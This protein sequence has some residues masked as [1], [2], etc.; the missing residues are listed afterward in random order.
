MSHGGGGDRWL[1]SYADFITLLMILFLVLYSMGQTDIEKYKKLAEGLKA[2]FGGGPVRIVDPK[3][4]QFGGVSDDSEPAPILI[5]DMPSIQISPEDVAAEISA[6]LAQYD[7][8]GEIS[9]ENNI[10][11]ILIALSEQ[12]LFIPGTAQLQPEAYHV[13]DRIADILVVFDNEIRITAHTDDQEPKDPRFSSNWELSVGRAL[14]IVEYLI[15]KGVPPEN[16]TAAGKGQY[17]PLYPNEGPES[18]L[19]SRAE[20][21]VIYPVGPKLFDFDIFSG[22]IIEDSSALP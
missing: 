19:N 12:L 9:V 17:H 11:G 1:V 18:A 7:M 15:S 13:L 4:S 2:A 14:T 16:L 6:A 8:V 22:T 5:A 21:T 10:E 20:I 3:I